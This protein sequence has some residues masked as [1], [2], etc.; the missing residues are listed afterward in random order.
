VKV[1][2][3]TFRLPER[4]ITGNSWVVWV[5]VLTFI[6]LF[7]NPAVLSPVHIGPKTSRHNPYVGNARVIGLAL[8]SYANDNDQQY[9]DASSSTETFQKLLDGDYI[10]DPTVFYIPMPGKVK[11]VPGQ[12]LKPEN[13]SWDIT[14]PVATVPSKNLPL[15]FMTGY[16]INYVS[17]GVAAPLIK[18]A[19]QYGIEGP[20]QTW[21][22]RLF[23][24]QS[25]NY[26][27]STGIAVFYDNNSASYIA[28]S[29][30]NTIP[31]IVPPDFKPDGKTYRQLTPD[32]VLR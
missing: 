13:V 21:F 24:K 10:T 27:P 8:Y 25:M 6:G 16:K 20:P 17:G 22:E 11:P 7:L 2:N 4:P 30:D 19:P 14:A 18:P 12:K 3:F 32:G 1:S 23:G 15:I 26:A 9:P 5:I 31:K 29:P 28:A